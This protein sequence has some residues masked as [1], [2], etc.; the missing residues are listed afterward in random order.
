[1]WL[2]GL[3]TEAEFPELKGCKAGFRYEWAEDA[4]TNIAG[5]TIVAARALGRIG[6]DKGER[7]VT[8]RERRDAPDGWSGR[9]R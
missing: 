5:S 7:V 1:V 4:T 9:R 3:E 8:Q 2:R 6:V